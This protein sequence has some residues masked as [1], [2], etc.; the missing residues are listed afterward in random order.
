MIVNN[1]KAT[2][3]MCISIIILLSISV[4]IVL[5]NFF[6]KHNKIT[7]E[8]IVGV[9]P[10]ASTRTKMIYQEPLTVIIKQEEKETISKQQEIWH[11]I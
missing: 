8:M 6:T 11:K 2:I 5:V 9:N 3:A 4:S 10:V 1:R 7:K